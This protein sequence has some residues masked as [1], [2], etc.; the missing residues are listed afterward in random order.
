MKESIPNLLTIFR[1][2]LTVVAIALVPFSPTHFYELLLGIFLV[3]AATD[4]LD[5]YLARR[6]HVE[7]DF[8]KIFDPLADKVLTFIF[9]VM[10]YSTGTIPAVIILLL[11]VRDLV[12]DSVRAVV[13]AQGK[14]VQAIMTAKIKTVLMFVLIIAALAS[15]TLGEHNAVQPLVLPL[16]I[17]A[18]LFSYVSAAQYGVVFWQ[19]YKIV[20]SSEKKSSA[21]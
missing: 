13:A 12:V 6:W 2:L 17:A 16:A 8:G 3:A 4:N 21:Q 18:L 10:L 15:L 5:G 7:S 14:V 1:V 20:K 11:I 9:L 19:H